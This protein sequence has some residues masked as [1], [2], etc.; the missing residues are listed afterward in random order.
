MRQN[1][2][3]DESSAPLTR[4]ETIRRIWKY[5]SVYRKEIVFISL[6]ALITSI[7]KTLIPLLTEKAID[8]DI[9]RG[10]VRGLVMTIST[11]VILALIWLIASV[12]RDRLTNRIANDCV[13]RVRTET[14]H[15]ILSLPLA[16]FD[17]RPSGRIITRVINDTDKLKE[18]TKSLTSTL[19]PSFVFL[20]SI[21]V[22]MVIMNPF[23][24]LSAFVVIPFMVIFTYLVVIRGYHN[25]ETFRKKESN[26]SSFIHEDYSGIRAIQSFQAEKETEKEC[27]RLLDESKN[28]WIKAVRRSD[29]FGIIISVSQALGY[30]MLFLCA[31]CWM[32]KGESSIGEILAFITY[33]GY[34]WQPIR[35][36]ASTY[37]TLINNLSAAARVFEMMDEKSDIIEADDKI[38]LK[39]EK[40]EVEFRNVTFSYPDDEGVNII[41]NLS[42]HVDG[43]QS[44]ALVG[45]TGAGKTTIINLLARFYDPV[46]GVVLIDGQNIRKVSFKSLRASLSVMPQDSM[47]FSGTI[48]ENLLYGKEASDEEMKKRVEELG[49]TAMIEALPSGYDTLI[50]DAS[51]SSGQ[52]Q[53]IALARTLIASPAILVLDE[54]TSNVDTIT[55]KMVQNGLKVLM[56]GRTS[57]IVAHRLSTIQNADIIFVVGE[58]TILEMGNHESLMKKKDGIYRKL[59]LSQFEGI[60]KEDE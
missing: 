32:E 7:S 8:E 15:N 49:L 41:E 4:R 31:V 11:A 54:A 35:Q 18:I 26:F 10:D 1:Y 33:I 50:K 12:V 9:K 14:Y 36:I 60:R 57:F 6:L 56:K 59:Y 34:F 21:M 29:A 53:L 48:R 3:K 24:A 28:A 52:K 16:F 44:I 19:V 20:I 13:Y 25:W 43:G 55:E 45:P 38:E 27:K 47:L 30:V 5:C 51:L 58:K 17:T 22:V 2:K 37:N 40:G 23:L 46:D 39:V 42:F